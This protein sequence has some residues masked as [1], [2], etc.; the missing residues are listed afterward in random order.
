MRPHDGPSPITFPASAVTGKLRADLLL[1]KKGLF[2]TRARAQEAIAAGLVVANGTVVKKPSETLA[3][4]ADIS[5]QAP[6]PYVSRGGV[7]LAAALDHFGIDP[8]GQ[9]CLDVGSSTGG[10]SD[11]L[12]KR[13]AAHVTAVDSGREQFHV[14]L[15]S[16]PRITL[17]EGTDIRLLTQDALAAAPTLAVIDV[18]FISLSLVLPAVAGLLAPAATIVALI[19]PQFEAGRGNIGKG[20]IVRDEAVQTQVVERVLAELAG[21]GFVPQHPVPSP[22]TGGDGNRE[23]LVAAARTLS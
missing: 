23:F 1:V 19:K 2:A 22:I 5:A 15:R 18:S 20:G 8:A 21:L 14:R 13:G 3:E 6:H 11:V 16:H 7:K 17:L 9:A 12:L 10:F 4:H